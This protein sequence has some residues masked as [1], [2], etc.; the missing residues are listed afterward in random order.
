MQTVAEIT[1]HTKVYENLYDD[2]LYQVFLFA[3]VGTVV[4]DDWEY[5][6]SV[7]YVTLLSDS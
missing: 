7:G 6:H 4:D 3:K 5:F 2:D 1:N